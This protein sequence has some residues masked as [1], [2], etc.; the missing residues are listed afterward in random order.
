MSE[1]K[2]TFRDDTIERRASAEFNIEATK[3]ILLLAGITED[4]PLYKKYFGLTARNVNATSLYGVYNDSVE[5]MFVITLKNPE[6]S[7]EQYEQITE[8]YRK[9]LIEEQQTNA[10]G[11]FAGPEKYEVLKGII[12]AT[13]MSGIK[14]RDQLNPNFPKEFYDESGKLRSRVVVEIPYDMQEESALGMI[15]SYASGHKGIE[16]DR[17]NNVILVNGKP[18]GPE[19]FFKNKKEFLDDK[20]LGKLSKDETLLDMEDEEL[21]EILRSGT[22]QDFLELKKQRGMARDKKNEALRGAIADECIFVDLQARM[23]LVTSRE[24]FLHQIKD[25]AY[26][27]ETKAHLVRTE[28]NKDTLE[29]MDRVMF[30]VS[31]YDV[32][33]QSTF[34]LWKS[35]MNARGCNHRYVDDAIGIG[36]IIAYG[37]DSKNPKKMLS[38]LL[39]QPYENDRGEFA[40]KV[41]PRI[42]GHEN[43]GFRNVVND[44]VRTHFNDGREGYFVFNREKPSDSEGYLYNDGGTAPFV[45]VNP[46]ENGVADLTKYTDVF[47]L[48]LSLLNI[49]EIKKVK[50]NGKAVLNNYGSLNDIDLSEVEALYLN[51]VGRIGDGVK[52]PKSMV[53]SGNIPVGADFRGVEDLKIRGTMVLDKDALLPEKVEV[54]PSSAIEGSLLSCLKFNENGNY[55][56]NN[57]FMADEGVS[58]VGDVTLSGII[59]PKINLKEAKSVILNSV[60]SMSEET[61]LPKKVE[62]KNSI[63]RDA[64]FEG[65]ESLVFENVAYDGEGKNL[66]KEVVLKGVCSG[67]FSEFDKI[68]LESCVGHN[69]IS[70]PKTVELI[71]T[72]IGGSSFEKAELDSLILRNVNYMHV[73]PNVKNVTCIGCIPENFD[74]SKIENLSIEE[75]VYIGMGAVLP[76]NV[77]IKDGISIS[78]YIPDGL[79]LSGVKGLVL[80]DIKDIGKGVKLPDDVVIKGEIE[81]D[82]DLSSVQGLVLKDITSIGE[83]VR[84]PSEVV[85]DGKSPFKEGKLCGV[86]KVVIKNRRYIGK[87]EVFPEHVVYQQEE[88]YLC[89]DVNIKTFETNAKTIKYVPDSVERLIL[90]EKEIKFDNV[91]D[92]PSR[93]EFVDG[94]VISGG[95]SKKVNLSEVNDL[96]LRDFRVGEN[97]ELPRK[98]KIDGDSEVNTGVDFSGV[99]ELVLGGNIHLG[100]DV[101]LPSNVRFE[102]E[103]SLSGYIPDGLDLSE[104]KGLRLSGDVCL[105]KNVKLPQDV[106]FDEGVV[107]SGSIPKGLD[108]SGVKDLALGNW[109]DFAEDVRLPEEVKFKST[110]GQCS[111]S[112]YI[113]KE[114]DLTR[115]DLDKVC[116]FNAILSGDIPDGADLTD[117]SGIKLVGDVRFGK[118]VKTNYATFGDC[119]EARFLGDVVVG[120]KLMTADY[121]EAT[122]VEFEDYIEFGADFKG[123]KNKNAHF[124]GVV[125]TADIKG[126]EKLSEYNTD[127]ALV[128]C[129]GEVSKGYEFS[130]SISKLAIVDMEQKNMLVVLNDENYTQEL[131]KIRGV[132]DEMAGRDEFNVRIIGRKEFCEKF[133]VSFASLEEKKEKTQRNES[134]I[135]SVRAKLDKK[136]GK[137]EETSSKQRSSE[138]SSYVSD[139]DI[140]R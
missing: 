29:I 12:D 54:E 88:C 113:P 116:Y 127:D 37:F 84:L 48:D 62:C 128:I 3:R 31:P 58:V 51:S 138:V 136:G 8:D 114:V 139:M 112:G 122:S 70:F 9:N 74:S 15:R 67:D 111:L 14:M 131:E 87:E 101:K 34:R 97:V 66:P 99:D 78:G 83:N 132:I 71:E 46:D 135:A 109:V 115:V 16:F 21:F 30:S 28:A 7:I 19:K 57:I 65:V 5:Q 33:T 43:I 10:I 81:N 77:N 90:T 92:L 41:N 89:Q 63:P 102:D 107:L 53:V 98:V 104:V 96:T 47:E 108:L 38:R 26:D 133:G 93:I 134:L 24:T 82:V 95:A 75:N 69:I 11:G 119:S 45:L 118:N 61:T 40:Y 125:V 68:S 137:S 32:A 49:E 22:Y 35:C 52:L 1:K 56:L 72:V 2:Y 17:D 123:P 140:E 79:D 13:V 25:V 64:N 130:D 50:S 100:Y 73:T 76:S 117:C 42:Y 23:E 106:Q 36:S 27:Y 120:D 103:L 85:I 20:F 105:G 86:E 94:V 124:N 126:L 39:I 44:V 60:T 59:K 129:C 18:V 4:N 91:H 110:S 80:K 121:S 6:M 55:G